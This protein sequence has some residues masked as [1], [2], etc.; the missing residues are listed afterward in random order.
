[1]KALLSLI[2]ATSLSAAAAAAPAESRKTLHIKITN[3]SS[4]GKKFIEF[5]KSANLLDVKSFNSGLLDSN[6]VLDSALAAR[7]VLLSGYRAEFEIVTTPNSARERELISEGH[8]DIAGTTQ[9]NFYREKL[10]KNC[11]I[12]DTVIPD[13][14]FEKGFFTTKEKSETLRILTAADLSKYTFTLNR[15]WEVDWKT[16]E[17]LH[18]KSMYD[19]PTRQ[20]MFSMVALGR[21]DFTLQSFSPNPDMSIEEGS[22][23]LYPVRGVK[24]TLKGTRHFIVSKHDERLFHVIEN[25]LRIMKNDGSLRTI[26]SQSGFYNAAT[27]NW[28]ILQP[29]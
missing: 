25:G 27:A 1:M 17:G 2:L 10:S 28:T 16:L 20:T 3:T 6:P 8:A 29:K 4:D 14:F 11:Y 18:P 5:I 13:G 9:W 15:N 19:S 21:A 23:K 22:I 26:L 24:M 12:T 7:A